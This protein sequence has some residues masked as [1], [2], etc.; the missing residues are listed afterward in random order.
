LKKSIAILL[1]ISLTVPFSGTY[2]YLQHKKHQI[3]KE[4]AGKIL[5]GLHEKEII[6]LKFTETETESRL[7]WKHSREFEYN[8]QMYDIVGKK[9]EGGLIYYYCYKDHK[10]TR[11]NRQK[12]KLIS[13]ALG[14][15]PT[16]KSQSDKLTNF[17][18]IIYSHEAFSW[19]SSS[20]QIPVFRFSLIV[21]HFSSITLT[22]LSPPPK[23]G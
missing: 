10:E 22:P 3:R 5:K 19:F 14:H 7:N 15:D 20:P 11:L 2:F 16:R 1:L 9:E 4:I 17:L 6:L 8:G 12:E 13:K 23:C 18:K 21:F